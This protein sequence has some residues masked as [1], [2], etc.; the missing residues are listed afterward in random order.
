MFDGV[1]VAKGKYGGYLYRTSK[2][3]DHVGM[4]IVMEEAGGIYTDFFGAPID[5]KNHL[6]RAGENY[7]LCAAP[8]ALHAQL[9][10]IIHGNK[11]G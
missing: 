2:I 4:H 11:D 7:T 3:W 8:P 5:Y 1:M 6:A 9:Q 10:K